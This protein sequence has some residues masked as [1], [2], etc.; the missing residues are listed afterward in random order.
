MDIKEVIPKPSREMP[1]A[2]PRALR[3]E[4]AEAKASDYIIETSPMVVESEQDHYKA[5]QRVTMKKED[6]Q[7]RNTPVLQTTQKLTPTF[8]T[9][10]CLGLENTE[11]IN[12]IQH[13]HF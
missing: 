7:V 12:P 1:V 9:H 11:S 13:P 5:V 6:K 3:Q 8:K 2:I 4:Q 10:C